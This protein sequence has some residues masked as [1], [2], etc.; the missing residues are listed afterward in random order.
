MSTIK[1]LLL[2]TLLATSAHAQV[3]PGPSMLGVASGIGMP[4]PQGPGMPPP[5]PHPGQGQPIPPG[6]GVPPPPFVGAPA[7]T[8]S[9]NRLTAAII[10]VEQFGQGEAAKR[11]KW[12]IGYKR[13]IMVKIALE[14]PLN[15]EE[16][17]NLPRLFTAAQLHQMR[18]ELPALTR[19]N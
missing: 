9:L 15:R 1:T 6:P 4:I 12:R 17:M 11:A 7:Q 3:P 2:I 18:T 13:S 14:I 10:T 8:V 19:K 16:E 5:P